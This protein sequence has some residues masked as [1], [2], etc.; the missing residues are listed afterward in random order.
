MDYPKIDYSDLENIEPV[1]G[2]DLD[3]EKIVGHYPSYLPRYPHLL[4]LKN[5]N[6][7]CRAES[8]TDDGRRYEDQP[9]VIRNKPKK[10]TLQECWVIYSRSGRMRGLAGEAEVDRYRCASY[11]VRHIPAETIEV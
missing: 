3:R 2:G 11:I 5:F 9:P 6:G 10:I 7:E 8:F 4:V 1:P